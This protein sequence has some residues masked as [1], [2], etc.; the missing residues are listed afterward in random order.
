MSSRFPRQELS[1]VVHPDLLESYRRTLA[2]GQR[3]FY[4]PSNV[5]VLGTL[6]TESGQNGLQRMTNAT[7]HEL[8]RGGRVD[9]NFTGKH[10]L[11]PMVS[12]IADGSSRV[13]SLQP[14]FPSK[15]KAF[16]TFLFREKVFQRLRLP[17]DAVTAVYVPLSRSER[18]W[19]FAGDANCVQFGSGA[20]RLDGMDLQSILIE[21]KR[22]WEAQD[23]LGAR[24]AYMERTATGDERPLFD[25]QENFWIGQEEYVRWVPLHPFV[26]VWASWSSAYYL[27]VEI[28]QEEP[29]SSD[30]PNEKEPV[31]FAETV[32]L[33][34]APRHSI[35]DAL[36]DDAVEGL[37]CFFLDGQWE[38]PIPLL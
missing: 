35:R 15:I 19:F 18:I 33:E 27:G 31:L 30:S 32:T 4:E 7:I 26:P 22:F 9:T 10:E 12:M 38:E 14:L 2:I 13:V 8:R 11:L 28:S 17:F 25:R 5:V 3:H 29:T 23:A 37:S 16:E 1:G 24:T 36:Q 34:N 6:P 20:G 21:S